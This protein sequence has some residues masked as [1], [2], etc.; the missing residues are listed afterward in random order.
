M[1]VTKKIHVTETKRKRNIL[2]GKDSD[3]FKTF[4]Q[5]TM[6]IIISPPSTPLLNNSLPKIS[7]EP[8]IIKQTCSTLH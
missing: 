5:A 8:E 4:C 6:I 7:F 2:H 3:F 1:R